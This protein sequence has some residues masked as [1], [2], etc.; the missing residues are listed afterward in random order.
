MG[1]FDRVKAM[2]GADRLNVA[3]RFELLR[4]AVHGTMSSFYMARDK[5]SGQIVGLKVLD[6]EKTKVFEARFQGVTKPSEGQIASA[7]AHPRIVRTF[8]HGLTSDGA[9]YLVM[10]YLPGQGLNTLITGRSPQL[11]GQRLWIIRQGA[12]AVGAVHAAGYIHR[13]VCPRNFVVDLENESLKLIDFGLTVPATAPFMQPGNRTG[14][15]KYMAPEVV[16]RRTTDR[17]L[18]VFAFGVTAFELFAGE[19]P[20]PTGVT[21][22][23]AAMAHDTQPPIQLTEASPRIDPTLA[24]AIHRCLA[25]KPENRPATMDE[26]LQLIETVQRETVS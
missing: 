15:P 24:A 5:Q 20:W 23:K 21:T 17:R 26:F 19:T 11:D 13:D 7:L 8:E 6:L 16:R 22:G 2:L 14:T 3:E 25:S 18:D 12:E 10:E 1:L 9:P 4:E